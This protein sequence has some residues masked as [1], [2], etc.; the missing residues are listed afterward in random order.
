MGQNMGHQGV[1][2]STE[3]SDTI[4][5]SNY[6]ENDLSGVQSMPMQQPGQM[7]TQNMQQ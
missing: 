1:Q 7:S 5:S 6:Q 2:N 3:P 4:N